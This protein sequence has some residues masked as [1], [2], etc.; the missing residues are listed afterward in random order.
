[1]K[2]LIKSRKIAQVFNARLEATGT[3]V[4]HSVRGEVAVARREAALRAV[5]LLLVRGG[6]ARCNSPLLVNGLL[7]EG[8]KRFRTEHEVWRVTGGLPVA[9]ERLAAGGVLPAGV[10]G[11]WSSDFLYGLV[12]SGAIRK[13]EGV[14]SFMVRS[15]A[16]RP[17]LR[18]ALEGELPFNCRVVKTVKMGGPAGGLVL[19]GAW[20]FRM[21]ADDPEGVGVLAGLL[22]GGYRL[23]HGGQ[24][25]IA[26]T[27]RPVSLALLDSYGVPYVR[28]AGWGVC[29]RV[30]VSPFWGALL[31]YEMPV[32]FG[33]WFVGW[34]SGRL[35]Q[36]GMCPLLPWA[37][38][39]A[40]WGERCCKGFPRNAVPF[41][42]DRNCLW[43][44]YGIGV[45]QVRELALRRL[46]FFRVDPRL[47]G[48]WLRR[49]EREGIM[50]SDFPVGKVPLDFVGGLCHN[51]VVKG[52][53]TYEH[54]SN[55]A[56]EG[57]EAN[58]GD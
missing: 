22:A 19:T 58:E 3:A 25:W 53:R 2:R 15:L 44:S 28:N 16:S 37:F 39:R 31:S 40:V 34:S 54:N 55:K 57:D 20:A 4:L 24:S 10:L 33:Q 29:G 35:I 6:R 27:A 18:A 48:V 12:M 43:G 49:M 41:L 5:C 52:D 42:V 23:E 56:N 36:R 32:V 8:V 1:M 17:A 21:G 9:A 7:P 46:G 38:L 51:E 26:L 45:G 11:E 30:L 50:V 13:A 14:Q 47:R